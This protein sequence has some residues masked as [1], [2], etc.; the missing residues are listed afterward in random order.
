M[1]PLSLTLSAFG[2]YAG[3]TTLDMRGL[4]EH[5]LYLIGGDTGAGKSTLFDAISFALYGEALTEGRGGDS[6]RSRYAEPTA[7]TFVSLTFS[8][9]E[10]EY[11]VRRNPEYIRLAKRGSAT[12]KERPAATLTMPDGATVNGVKAVND[13][14]S[15]ILGVSAEQ[16]VGITMIAQGDFR[17]LLL[18]GTEER[19]HIFRRLFRTDRYNLLTEQLKKKSTALQSEVSLLRKSISAQLEDLPSAFDEKTEELL[20][21]AKEGR[22]EGE[23][24]LSLLESLHTQ[25]KI[26]LEALE[27]ENQTLQRRMTETE[28]ALTRQTECKNAV[29][30]AEKLTAEQ[31]KI[32]TERADLVLEK[33]RL[34]S[35]DALMRELADTILIEK[36]ALPKYEQLQK[37]EKAYEALVEAR[38]RALRK[39]EAA[40]ET[41]I[42]QAEQVEKTEKRIA[43]ATKAAEEHRKCEKEL[44]GY[45][46]R[47][48]QLKRLLA[49][50]KEHGDAEK[51]CKSLS[52]EY[53]ALC[54]A[55]ETAA[56]IYHT[57]HRAYLD[58]QAGILAA[59]LAAGKPCP[60]CGSTKHPSPASTCDLVPTKTE[61]DEKRAI[62]EKRAD[63][64][65]KVS[66]KI[67]AQ[68]A[69][70]QRADE[71]IKTLSQELLGADAAPDAAA[72][73]NERL[74][75]K[76]SSLR[77]R[78]E[79]YETLLKDILHLPEV[80]AKAKDALK[81]AEE[82]K[83]LSRTALAECDSRLLAD[84]KH[85]AALKD[86][87]SFES[88]EA[89]IKHI[90]D[91]E[92][93]LSEY[94]ENIDKI[95][96]NIDNLSKKIENGAGRL[97]ELSR[98]SAAYDE[99][100]YH[101]LCEQKN[102]A[103]CQREETDEKIR[104]SV[105]RV[106]KLADT[107]ER[108]EQL[109][110]RLSDSEQ[111]LRVYAPLADTAAGTLSGKE[112]IMLETY[113]QISA[114]ER[115]IVR[116]NRRFSEMSGGQYELCRRA[117]ASDARTQS[118]LDL[119]VVDHYNGSR[120]PASTLSG[121][122]SFMASLSLALG[123]SD[124]M[125]AAAGGIRMECMF[126]DEGFGSLD[127]ESLK[128]ALRALTALSEG[129]TLVGVISHVAYLK[130]RI[131][132]QILVTKQRN[133][134][135]TISL[136]LNS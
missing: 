37:A 133:G 136:H 41:C 21:D 68:K 123:L 33:E 40:I 44:D 14:I 114:F 111:K 130:E 27:T 96:T 124:E 22:M 83:E 74:S 109:L 1:R 7:Q 49:A 60:V 17:R 113:A 76:I 135:S 31:E 20:L 64:R 127:E 110:D 38:M 48:G 131:P 91:K 13:K 103:L 45:L 69:L 82:E 2:P 88:Y 43:E 119:D 3:E 59:A 87:L 93:V 105:V 46:S 15:D 89:A 51:Q 112:K 129:R 55:E 36:K 128:L 99:E 104:A 66:E 80:L 34:L 9:A 6:L 117:E 30:T 57:A 122:E 79:V 72:K 81:K 100:K 10:K 19:R 29:A 18:S 121:G 39:N 86:E 107:K 50:E 102:A 62:W 24:I 92:R 61:V 75:V 108:V 126:V 97:A 58:G 12:T 95:Q 115:V 56:E 35:K 106:S 94:R 98:I 28:A 42:A 90:E 8:Y 132:N 67:S 101:Q 85:I 73:E 120:R 84:G 16:F 5:G 23:A 116:A 63:E 47:Q 11:T 77:E 71:E 118:G 32:Q 78:I 26:A 52:E 4:G 134:G 53:E 54:T 25:E 65:T 70:L 125:Q